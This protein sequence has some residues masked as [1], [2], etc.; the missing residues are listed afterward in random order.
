M[1]DKDFESVDGIVGERM[2]S[3]WEEEMEGKQTKRKRRA[4][5]P[6]RY[7]GKLRAGS[8]LMLQGTVSRDFLT[9]VFDIK[10]VL[11]D[12]PRKD[13]KFFRIFKEFRIRNRLPGVFTT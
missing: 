12:T 6:L 5:S 9:L 2:H 4:G 7:G 3:G 10:Q 8:L 13:F 1:I 11:L